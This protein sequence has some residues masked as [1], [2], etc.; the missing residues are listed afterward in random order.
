M[1]DLLMAPHGTRVL[2]FFG[3]GFVNPVFYSMANA[4]G[5]EYFYAVGETL[6]QD[7][8]PGGSRDLDHFRIAPDCL[9]ESLRLMKLA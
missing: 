2:E 3:P 8:H 9:R 7:R 4:L 6:A 5:Q 1:T